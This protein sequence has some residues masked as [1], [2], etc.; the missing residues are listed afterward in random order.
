MKWRISVKIEH[1]LKTQLSPTND[2]KV[3]PSEE[4]RELKR[5]WKTWW[6][7]KYINHATRIGLL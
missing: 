2:S 7:K 1:V 3:P 4:K 5:A 6:Y